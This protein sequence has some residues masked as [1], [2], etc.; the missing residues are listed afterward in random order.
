MGDD[1]ASSFDFTALMHSP[2]MMSPAMTRPACRPRTS[3]TGTGSVPMSASFPPSSSTLLGPSVACPAAFPPL[4]M[5]T[6]VFMEPGCQNPSAQHSG[7]APREHVEMPS[8]IEMPPPPPRPRQEARFG[9]PPARGDAASS[10]LSASTTGASSNPVQYL[11][12]STSTVLAGS[13]ISRPDFSLLVRSMASVLKVQMQTDEGSPIE[14]TQYFLTMFTASSTAA[15]ETQSDCQS[16]S[17]G[18][19]SEASEAPLTTP[20]TDEIA[21]FVANVMTKAQLGAE[22]LVIALLYTNRAILLSKLPLGPQTWRG[23]ILASLILAQKVWHDHCLATRFF[24]QIVPEFSMK[25]LKRFEGNLLNLLKFNV[26]V[27]QQLYAQYYFELRSVYQELM[28]RSRK[29]RDSATARR[30]FPLLP[31]SIT[32]ARRLEVVSASIKCQTALAPSSGFLGG[33]SASG[34]QHPSRSRAVLS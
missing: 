18:S 6:D 7:G 12:N 27:T 5:S 34:E 14:L 30:E 29:S 19:S 21:K 15:S 4:A 20:S 28:V 24:T 2:P 25:D 8:N 32:N 26:K 11:N 10:A 3:G 13:T 9:P 23:V 22:C 17:S 33:P 1:G 31:L 16:M